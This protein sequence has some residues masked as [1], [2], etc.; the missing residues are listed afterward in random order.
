MRRKTTANR[1]LAYGS[2]A[3]SALL[4][5]SG[6]GRPDVVIASSP[7]LPVGAEIGISGEIS[8]ASG[9]LGIEGRA[10]VEHC[11]S[12]EDGVCRIGFSLD[13]AKISQL[14]DPETFDRR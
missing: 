9:T 13:K 14:E 5:G 4:A 7:P 6:V 10:K 11:R 1:L 12:T 8:S 3:A 2:F